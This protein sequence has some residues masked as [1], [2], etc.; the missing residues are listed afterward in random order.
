MKR[1]RGV[2]PFS[3]IGVL[4]ESINSL[5]QLTYTLSVFICQPRKQTTQADKI[6]VK[7]QEQLLMVSFHG[8]SSALLKCTQMA[9]NSD[10]HTHTTHVGVT[11]FRVAV[12]KQFEVLF[13][14]DN[15][16]RQDVVVG[17]ARD[18]RQCGHIR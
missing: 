2:L 15:A 5:T 10:T 7:S 14:P 16:L 18:R 11:Y 17:D 3:N 13:L 1:H 12:D 6:C 9:T 4:A 8:Q